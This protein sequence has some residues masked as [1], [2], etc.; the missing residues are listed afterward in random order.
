MSTAVVFDGRQ[1]LDLVPT[2]RPE[3]AIIHLAPTCTDAFS[4][5]VGFRTADAARNIPIF[6]LLDATPQ[7]REEAFFNTGLR[8]LGTRANLQAAQLGD[9][10]ATALRGA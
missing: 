2:V 5:L 4:A 8:L 1:A 6:F 7:Q 9:Q 10:L 3:A